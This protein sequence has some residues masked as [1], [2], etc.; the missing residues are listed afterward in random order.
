AKSRLQ[1]QILSDIT[2]LPVY[3][4]KNM[5]LNY[6]CRGAAMLAGVSTRIY[7]NFKSVNDVFR[8]EELIIFPREEFKDYY[9][10]KFEK[11]LK[12]VNKNLQTL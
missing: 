7:K 6:A 11:Y 10:D 8:E 12:I 1:C 4:P 3:L 5:K 2:G 9:L